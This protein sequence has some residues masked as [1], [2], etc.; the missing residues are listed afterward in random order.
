MYVR[1]LT[2]PTNLLLNAVLVFGVPAL[3]IPSYGVA[4]AAAGTAVANGL[5][6]LIFLWLF[7]S[8]RR[9]VRLRVGGAQWDTALATELVRVGA[10]LAGTRLA[11]T[12][13]RFP[14]LFVLGTL[15]TPVLAGYAIGRRVILLAMMPAWGYSTASSTLVG[16]AIGAGEDEEADDYGWQTLRIALVTQLLIAVA[17]VAAARPI[18]LAFQTESV[19][20]TVTFV[21]VFGLTVA[22]FAIARTLR[23]GL[24]G[25]GDTRWPLYGTLAGTWAFRLPVAFLA[26]PPGVVVLSV[27]GFDLAPGL[28][29]GLVAVYVAILGDMYVRAGVNTYRFWSGRWKVVARESEAGVGPES[30]DD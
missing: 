3:G 26:I 4:G 15:G 16:Q 24:R 27:G 25:A 10:P 2:L 21:R 28:G 14:F 11:Q 5:A 6:A 8:G 29:L 9:D 12:F 23:G 17:V 1:V 20:L 22:G 13:G 7:V 19:D 18:A 30:A